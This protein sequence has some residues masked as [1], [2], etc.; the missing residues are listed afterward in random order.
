[1]VFQEF[2]LIPAM[3][4]RPEHPAVARA[5]GPTRAHRRPRDRPAGRRP[6]SPGSAPTS[7]PIASSRSCRSVRASWWRSPRPSPRTRASSSSMSRPPRSPRPRSSTLTTA[8]RRLTA[9]GISVIYI[10]HHLDEVMAIC[11]RVTVLRDGDVTLVAR[12]PPETTL[13]T[14]HREHARPVARERAGVPATTT[15][16]G[17]GDRSCGSPACRNDRLRDISFDLYRGEIV[18]VAGPAGQRPERAHAGHLR[19]RPAR[20]PGA[21]E[22]DGRAVAHPRS[23]ATPSTPGSPSSPRIAARAGLVREHSVGHNILMAAWRAVRPRRASST[24]ARPGGSASGFVEQLNIRTTGPRPAG[25]GPL[26][27]QPAEGR[28]R[29][30]PVGP[31]VGA[32][33]RRSDGRCRCR[34]QARDPDAGAGAGRRWQRHPAGVIGARGAQRGGRPGAG[35]RD[36]AILRILDRSAGDDL[37][38]AALSRAVQ[39]EE[40]S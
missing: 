28:R 17:P 5:E 26:R 29:E 3:S 2:S 37:S 11:D 31:A 33:P 19:H 23:A 14:D 36:G 39:E 20:S 4:G 9:E 32:A 27:R 1:M 12:R 10:S 13:S 22:I 35:R 15:S 24:T 16:T 18:G 21:I 34:L 8:V 38:E 25:E 6:R 30:E 7:T 40:A